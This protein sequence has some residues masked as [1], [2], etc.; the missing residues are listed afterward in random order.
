MAEWLWMN[1]RL[2]TGVY[3][4]PGKIDENVARLKLEGM[5]ITIDELTD[6]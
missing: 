2:E 6:Q 1:S 3:D 4:V 5:S